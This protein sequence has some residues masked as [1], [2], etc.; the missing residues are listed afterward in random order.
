MRYHERSQS[1]GRG[2]VC[3]SKLGQSVRSCAGYSCFPI[4][5]SE[6]TVKHW[7]CCGENSLTRRRLCVLWCAGGGRVATSS[8]TNCGGKCARSTKQDSVAQ[9]SKLSRSD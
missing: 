8:Q 6:R 5:L 7:I 4:S 2:F 9:R 1:P 3:D